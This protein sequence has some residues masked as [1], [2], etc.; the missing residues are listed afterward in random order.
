MAKIGFKR[1]SR[2]VK[3]LTS[4]IHTQI[5]KA[6]TRFTTTGLDDSNMQ[7]ENSRFRITFPWSGLRPKTGGAGTPDRRQVQASFTLAPP[8]E[9][10]RS[11]GV[12][13]PQD[14][15]YIL[16]SVSLSIDQRAEAAAIKENGDIDFAEVEHVEFTVNLFSKKSEVFGGSGVFP[17]NQLASVTFDS[18]QFSNPEF[19]ESPSIKTGLG[20][21]VDPYQVLLVEVDLSSFQASATDLVI[22]SLI[23]TLDF[24]APLMQRDRIVSNDNELQNIPTSHKGA[25][26]IDSVTTT[27]PAADALIRAENNTGGDGI[28]TALKKIDNVFYNR[29]K[30]GYGEKSRNIYKSNI[31]NDAGY[32]VIAVPMWGNGWYC[33]GGVP[34]G[35]DTPSLPLVGASPYSNP[36]CDR[37]IIPLQ[38]PMV[39]HHVFACVNVGGVPPTSATF[40]NK[41]GVGLGCG[42]RTDLFQSRQLAFASWTPANKSLYQIDQSI[43]RTE[44]MQL[45]NIPLVYVTGQAGTGYD[46]NAKASLN[47]TGRPVFAGQALSSEFARTIMAPSVGAAVPGGMPL[48]HGMDQYLEIR[49]EIQDSGGIDNMPANEGVIGFGGHWVYIV[50]KKH[51]C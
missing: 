36:S 29:L 20:I 28:E 16:D 10:F 26:S 33:R 13:F 7:A 11:N 46:N 40:T 45:M 19:V 12:S 25:R 30:G 5:Q 43:I 3:L 47:A 18:L 17:D 51:L 44:N 48:M 32:E 50:G 24:Y 31:L 14:I 1:L 2:G 49:W 34:A 39:I 9:M 41:V 6:L 22:N 37:R 4:H 23:L 15:N 35:D 27:A 8:Q 38:F 21:S 42:I